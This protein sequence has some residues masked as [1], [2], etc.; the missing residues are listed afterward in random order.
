M[1]AEDL[2]DAL[3]QHRDVD[4]RGIRRGQ[5]R[6]HL[7]AQRAERALDHRPHEILA[8]AE[9][10]QDRGVRDADVGG[11]LLQPD[12]G[13]PAR[14]EAR[15]GGVEDGALGVLGRAPAAGRGGRAWAGADFRLDGREGMNYLQHCQLGYGPRHRR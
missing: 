13:R 7:L 1:R 5:G 10:V 8:A 15:L 11:D 6:E 4:L 14:R 2:E 12:A 9:V 3:D